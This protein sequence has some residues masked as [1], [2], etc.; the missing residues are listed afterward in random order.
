MAAMEEAQTSR[1]GLTTF[2]ETARPR[3]RRY[4]ASPEAIAEVNQ[5]GLTIVGGVRYFNDVFQETATP[6]E[7]LTGLYRGAV[8]FGEGS[9]AE[10]AYRR[11]INP[12]NDPEVARTVISQLEGLQDY[13]QNHGGL[14]AVR[15]MAYIDEEIDWIRQRAGIAKPSVVRNLA[16]VVKTFVTQP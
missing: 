15:H 11:F 12:D 5:A 10:E 1:E 16:R 3:L 9:I 14:Q 7:Q 6:E 13:E 4:Y 8:A 2:L